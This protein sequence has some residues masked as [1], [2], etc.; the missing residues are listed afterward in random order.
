[1]KVLL[2]ERELCA[3]TRLLPGQYL[4]NEAAKGLAGDD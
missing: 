3:T 4:A 2:Q 1:M